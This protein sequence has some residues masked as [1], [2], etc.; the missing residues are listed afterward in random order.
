MFFGG[1]CIR[2]CDSPG[3]I[4]QTQAHTLNQQ[5]SNDHRTFLSAFMANKYV[6]LVVLGKDST[7]QLVNDNDENR[8]IFTPVS[9]SG[10]DSV[11]EF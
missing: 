1:S 11:A 9:R 6:A 8:G 5:H 7:D 10:V 3:V 4:P 2:G